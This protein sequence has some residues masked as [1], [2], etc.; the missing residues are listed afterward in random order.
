MSASSPREKISMRTRLLSCLL[1]I[2]LLT[3]AGAYAQSAASVT[4][5]CKDGSSFSGASRSGACRGHGGVGTWGS[6]TAAAP[7]ATAPAATAPAATAPAATGADAAAPPAKTTD[8]APASKSTAST[9][10]T[11]KTTATRAGGGGNGQVWVNS[12]SKIY[13][14]EGTR[15]YGKTKSGTYMS[16]SAA[17]AAGDRPSGG[18]TC[19]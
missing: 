1:G 15:Y 16:E 14:C 19:S 11:K 8:S 18:K 13:H 17:K 6:T 4:A 3:T 10:N 9:A 5:T 12:S 7:A 2:G